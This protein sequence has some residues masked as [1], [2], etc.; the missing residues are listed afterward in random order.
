MKPTF[1]ASVDLGTLETER[2]DQP[3]FE[4]VETLIMRA[5]GLTIALRPSVLNV[6]VATKIGE[7]LQ[8]V[9]R[10]GRP[11]LVTATAN[12]E[13]F[14]ILSRVD[15]ASPFN[16]TRMGQAAPKAAAAVM[17]FATLRGLDLRIA[18]KIDLQSETP[19]G[20]G[21]ASSSQD[22]QR[23]L[24]DVASWFNV[25]TT[26][27]ELY[28]VMCRIERS[29]F[30]FRPRRL[31]YAIPTD[32]EFRDLAP[33]P[34]MA[35]VVWDDAVD[36]MVSTSEVAHLDKKRIHFAPIYEDLLSRLAEG[37]LAN[38]F[39]VSTA[40]AALSQS[41]I[42]KRS[43]KLAT[44]LA[45]RAEGGVIVAHT[46]TMVGVLLP[47]DPMLVRRVAAGVRAAGVAPIIHTLG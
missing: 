15:G 47:S 23:A 46:G 5:E 19:I 32:G 26:A 1:T 39:A 7:L 28:S 36:G 13:R 29:D 44:T 27:K 2:D 41:L 37:T 38:T 31:V 12:D 43:F 34:S 24:L 11:I 18:P 14:P 10:D 16:V 40:S 22:Q 33:M 25:P 8:G 42:P 4:R 6:P 9:S 30:L 35:A 20:K 17:C 3:P 45:S 21:R